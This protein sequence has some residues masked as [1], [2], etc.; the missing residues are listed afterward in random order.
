MLIMNVDHIA[1][2]H[3]HKNAAF[4]FPYTLVEFM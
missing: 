3:V 4:H 1:F 2:Y